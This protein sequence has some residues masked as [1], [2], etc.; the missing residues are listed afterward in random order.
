MI[1]EI[2][3]WLGTD[4]NFV[5]V[6]V[7][8]SLITLIVSIVFYL[9]TILYVR[10]GVIH[11]GIEKSMTLYKEFE[12]EILSISSQIEKINKKIIKYKRYQDKINELHI[13][14]F[15]KLEMLALLVNKKY[16]NVAIAK[17]MFASTIK[18]YYEEEYFNNFIK[19]QRQDNKTA[20]KQ[21]EKLY[22]KW[23]KHC[24]IIKVFI[25]IKKCL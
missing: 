17:E 18:E 8:I 7:V 6:T 10:R 13:K 24:F 4:K 9:F 25:C 11:W 20:Y 21:L 14:L 22:N 2:I 3:N 15:N 5:F 19:E 1:N 12:E 23:N 16:I